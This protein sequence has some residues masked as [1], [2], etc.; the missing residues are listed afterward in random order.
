MPLP[1]GSLS[2]EVGYANL[3]LGG[4]GALVTAGGTVLGNAAQ[5]Q[6]AG[7]YGQVGY[8]VDVV[9]PWVAYE[10]WKSDAAGGLGASRRTAPA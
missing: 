7:F 2:A 6:G 8:L 1:V 4:G 10:E 3:D 5:S 9:Q